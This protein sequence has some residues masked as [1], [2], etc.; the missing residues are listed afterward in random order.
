MGDAAVTEEAI[1][2]TVYPDVQIDKRGLTCPHCDYVYSAEKTHKLTS[3]EHWQGI[4]KC[5]KCV[6][7]FEWVRATRV[8]YSTRAVRVS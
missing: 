6:G 8:C 4:L 5:E 2:T 1:P 3:H 7:T